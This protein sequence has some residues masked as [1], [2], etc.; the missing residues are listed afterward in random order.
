MRSLALWAALLVL[1]YGVE[2][3]GQ[4]TAVV[5]TRQTVVH[6]EAATDTPRLSRLQYEG[7]P[8]WINTASEPLI[9]TLET[10]GQEI[11]LHWT[12][13]R[14]LSRVT[15]TSVTFVYDSASPRL[16]LSWEW[17]ARSESGPVEHSIRIENLDAHEIWL[18]LQDSF[19]FHL[20]VSPQQSLSEMH[21]DKGAGKP[22]KIGTHLD[23]VP[24]GYLWEG[25]SSS[26]ARDGS[27]EIIP[28]F[29]VERE[30][31]SH[32]GWYTGI[33]F[34][35]RTHLVLQ[36][37]S[38]SLYGSVGLDPDPGP[39]RTRLR[40]NEVFQSPTVLL[41]GF[42]G[43]PDG[44][45]NILRSWVR[46]V[47]NNPETW[48]NPEYPLLVN[49]T[50][51]A[52]MQ[53]DE[54]HAMRMLRDASALG[55]E[56]FHIDAGWFRGVGDWYP[57]P[58]KFPHGLVPIA[59][60]AHRRGMKF[61]IWVNWA[62]AGVDTNPGALNARNPAIRDWLV[63]D[64]PPGW[65]PKEFVGRTMD[66]GVP[67]VQSYAQHEVNR[68]VTDYD[69]D[70]LEH[71][72]YLVAKNCARTDHPHANASPPQMSVVG[73]SGIAMP[74]ASNS[75]DVDYHTVN[76]YYDIYSGL[77]RKHP[78]LLLEICNDGGRMVD[79]GT[80]AHGDYFSITDS[81]DP[82][83][84]RRAFYDAS[85]LLPPAMLEAYVEKWPTSSTEQFLYMLRS[86]MMGWL[87][88]MQD[89]TAWTPEQ[90][91]AARIEFALYKKDLRPLIRDAELYHVSQRPDGIHWD[92]IEYF[93]P[94]RGKGVLFAFR[95]T[96]QNDPSHSF[97]LQGLRPD[98]R[99]RLSFRDHSD[100]NRIAYG[101]DLST[102]GL[103][104]VLRQPQTSELVS[105]DELASHPN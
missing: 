41:G 53:I 52:G 83:S 47:L 24:S 65:S 102:Q 20:Q 6:L 104:V 3:D 72:G 101:R 97:V 71:D 55:L 13:N 17:E 14:P 15:P 51:G 49:N 96:Q 67:A 82:L 26:Y 98:D 79:F 42:R 9:A 2:A 33:E 63:A 28:W 94:K 90:H 105:V 43:G 64:T 66:L 58:A 10:A 56:M 4:I 31:P 25:K 99:Y 18:P 23:D 35:G 69:L 78:G 61:G 27:D 89:T 19:D 48:K 54:A 7:L 74:D 95:G 16:R 46:Q 100:A 73:G 5:R 45:G 1:T 68:I 103:R 8:A 29:M 60:E 88:I 12:L 91:A 86:G 59:N 80:A 21:I 81:Y 50:W 92:G 87:T 38:A 70:M 62:Q 22:T 75:T 11:P 93:D 32:D 39:F 44:L 34:S 85:H 37:D 36:R 40:P 30:G 76:A 77:R 84:N 57:D